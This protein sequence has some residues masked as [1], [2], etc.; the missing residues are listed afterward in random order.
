MI[1]DTLSFISPLIAVETLAIAL[2]PILV[3]LFAIPKSPHFP[4]INGKRLFEISDASSKKRYLTDAHE[5]IKSGLQKASVFRIISDNGPKTVLAPKY[6][7]EIRS[8]PGLSFGTSIEDEFH[9]Y[10]RGFEPFQLGPRSEELFQVAIRTKL[11][12]SLA[13][14][15]EPLSAETCVVLEKE[16]TNNNDWHNLTLKPC[17][18]RMVAQLSSKVF[19]GDQI[20]R[21]PNW[22]RITVDY[23][24]DSFIA[25]VA[26]R[27]WPSFIRP[28][29]ANFLPACQKTRRELD[30]AR[31]IIKPVLQ[32]RREA[33]EATARDGRTTVRFNDAMQWMEDVAKGRP[34]DAAVVQMS[35]S[36]VAIHTTSDMLTQVLYDLCGKEDIIQAL[37]LEVINVVREEGWGKQSLHKLKIMDSVLKESQRL[38]PIGVA[39]MRRV[40]TEDIK[41]SD[42]NILSKGT[43]LLVSGDNMWDS[44]IYPDPET[45]DPYRFLKLREV[46]G[47][48]TSAQLVAPSADHFGFGYGNHACPGRFFAVNEVK[49]AL[50]H[51]LLKYDIKLAPGIPEPVVSKIGLSRN[52]DN[53]T[54]VSVRRRQEEIIL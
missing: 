21:D 48:E 39:S 44:R 47:H 38:K 18:L 51:M 5:L 8:H 13:S 16:W 33:K 24:V 15:M 6:A 22:L 10:V 7:T 43:S 14:V 42:G 49:I 52:C 25:A 9:S 4:L 23:T 20:C 27:Q 45:F 53:K 3:Y 11:T 40:A 32:A 46:P 2:L 54:I 12:Q 36:V 1:S 35:F 26:L 34:Y 29:V 17:I 28:L 30:E 37:R 31:S 41:L 19:L 50:A